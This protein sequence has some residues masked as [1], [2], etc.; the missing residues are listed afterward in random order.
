MS[1][2]R[3]AKRPT[4]LN[5][6]KAG[7]SSWQIEMK[8]TRAD[9]DA[10]PSDLRRRLFAYLEGLPRSEESGTAGSRFE[11]QD[12]AALLRDISFHRRG[13]SLRAILD[14]LTYDDEANPPSRLKLG[15]ALSS[16]DRAKLGRYVAL[17]NRL[18]AKAAKKRNTQ[19]CRFHRGKNIYTAHS[20][21]RRWLRE[22]LPGIEHAGEQEEPL[23]G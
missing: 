22:L 3:P 19:L 21:T 7:A 13:R 8:L 14:R 10:M 12:V 16:T 18:A 6:A 15:E 5:A 4:L 17:L 9:L 1:N 11:R 2:K 20:V 23:W